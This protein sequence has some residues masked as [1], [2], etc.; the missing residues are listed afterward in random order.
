MTF[1]DPLSTDSALKDVIFTGGYNVHPAEIERV[2]AKHPAVAMV[3]VGR[4]P[5]ETKG[6]IAVAPV[7]RRTGEEV[8]E[9]EII[10][11]SAEELAAY[12]RPRKV[13]FTD[14]LPT[15]SSGKIM[16]RKLGPAADD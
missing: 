11:F 6:E 14:A 9:E 16:R 2:I 13:V 5:D 4:E 12:K 1:L 3:A 8:S 10:A 15:T 7:V